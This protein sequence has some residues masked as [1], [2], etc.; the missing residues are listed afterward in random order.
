VIGFV[1]FADAY[2]HPMGTRS[3]P[4]GYRVGFFLP[5]SPNSSAL[6][7]LGKL[8]GAHSRPSESQKNFYSSGPPSC[9]TAVR[10]PVR[11]ADVREGA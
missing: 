5:Y 9:L 7:W 2:V 10:W 1:F 8:G 3:S 6:V 4:A 11:A